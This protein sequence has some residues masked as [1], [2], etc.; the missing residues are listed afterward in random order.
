MNSFRTKTDNYIGNILA[1]VGLLIAF[2][3]PVLISVAVSA[4]QITSR[5]VTLSSSSKEVEDVDYDF[6]F[7]LPNA[8]GA[9][10]IEF[11]ENSPL[12]GAACDAPSGFDA[13]GATTS[14]GTFSIDVQTA[15]TVELVET[16]SA[17]AIDLTLEGIDNPTAAGPLYARIVTYADQTTKDAQYTNAQTLGT[18]I[19]DGGIAISITDSIGV[20]AAVLESLTFCVSDSA[21]S[22]G[23][24]D[25]SFS[26]IEL[27]ETT[28]SVTAL[29]STVTSTAEMYSQIST[30]AASGAVVNLKSSAV[31]CGGL[32]NSSDPS[33][34]YI[35]P[36][37]NTGIAG[38]EAKFGVMADALADA[39][40][41][42]IGAFDVVS[43]SDYNDTTYALN[44]VSGDA[45][46]VTSTYG[47]PF[48]DT[49]GAPAN[50]KNV[51]IT[52]GAGAA[53]GT[54]AGN[55]STD[56]SLIATGTY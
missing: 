3:A 40:T 4:D 34:C 7:T 28:G 41:N 19:D 12:I 10:V 35:T 8:A 31:G 23:C 11:C 22:D 15:T 33:E 2:V 37:L 16:M 50:N 5:S 55:Y 47:D 52:F 6:D 36:A 13:S 14:S 26:A 18:Y 48:L 21:I 39:N 56:I 24:G 20:S 49:A 54:P 38:G 53:A 51:L 44:Y 17:G 27:G 42:P 25:A 1:A 45:T 30:N 46:G 32:I 43:A 9:V 29:S